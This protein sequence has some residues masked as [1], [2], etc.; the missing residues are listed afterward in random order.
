MFPLCQERVKGRTETPSSKAAKFSNIHSIRKGPGLGCIVLLISRSFR[1]MYTLSAGG[2]RRE[3]CRRYI[4][5]G[6]SESG[7]RSLLYR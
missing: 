4:H 5:E 6:Q 7:A 2:S 3:V 1:G